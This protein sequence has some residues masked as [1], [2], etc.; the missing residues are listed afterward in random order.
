M[1]KAIGKLTPLIVGEMKKRIVLGRRQKDIAEEFSVSQAIVSLIRSGKRYGTEPWPNGKV[2][3]YKNAYGMSEEEG[4]LLVNV[5]TPGEEASFDWSADA[6]SFMRWPD[7]AQRGILARVN[8][9]RIASGMQPHPDIS[10]EWEA[11]LNSP[12][13]EG[14]TEEMMRRDTAF[15]AEDM[16]R[17][18]IFLE[19][20][21]YIEGQ[22]STRK[23]ERIREI[24]ARHHPSSP[25]ALLQG[26]ARQKEAKAPIDP[27]VYP[28]IEWSEIVKQDPRHPLIRDVRQGHD[29]ALLEAMCIIF[30]DI[31]KQQWRDASTSICVRQAKVEVERSKTA[32]QV[33][34]NK[35]TKETL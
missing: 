2:G 20:E 7:Y 35:L 23:N 6:A 22:L 28:V 34:A 30:R 13:S 16:R 32:M 5:Y 29:A 31:P 25:E 17:G 24:V 33:A 1:G 10:V 3:S 21:D 18:S 4:K 11:Y 9:L 15:H 27:M 19:F 12:A 14:H 8:T 26:I